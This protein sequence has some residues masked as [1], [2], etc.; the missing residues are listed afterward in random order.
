MME[1]FII[2]GTAVGM[3]MVISPVIVLLA[4]RNQNQERQIQVL[5]R[6]LREVREERDRALR[7]TCPTHETPHLDQLVEKIRRQREE[8]NRLERPIPELKAFV[9]YLYEVRG[10]FISPKPVADKLC[11]LMG[12]EE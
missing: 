1:L 5:S 6:R 12:W 3:G 4:R 8:I 10:A 11:A 2:I 7:H 9:N